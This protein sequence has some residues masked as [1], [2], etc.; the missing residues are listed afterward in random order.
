MILYT[1]KKEIMASS[2]VVGILGVISFP[3]SSILIQFTPHFVLLER[4][5]LFKIC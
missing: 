1:K 2:F 4:Y 3:V 5:K